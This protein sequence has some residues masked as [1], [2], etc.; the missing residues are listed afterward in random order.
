MSKESIRPAPDASKAPT[1]MF[2]RRNEFFPAQGPVIQRKC[3]ECA[4]E[5]DKAEVQTKLAIGTPDDSYER[6][7]DRVADRIMSGG[8]AVPE[9]TGISRIQ[10]LPAPGSRSDSSAV[11]QSRIDARRGSGRPLPASAQ[12]FFEP[13]LGSGL[14][15]VR[16]HSDPEAQT[17]ARSVNARAFTYGSDI[18]FGAGQYKPDTAAGQHLM[19]HELTHTV[20]QDAARRVQRAP[21]APIEITDSR[22]TTVPTAD[23]RIAAASCDI[24]CDSVNIGV[25]HAMPLSMHTSRGPVLAGAAGSNG[26]GAALHFIRNSTAIPAGNACQTCTDWKMI[27]ILQTNMTTDARAKERY[28]DNASNSTPF[29]D[30]AYLTGTGRHSIPSGY[31]D[32]GR[33]VNTTRSIYDR[34]FRTN[35]NLATVANKDFFWRAETHVVGV[36]PGKD[37]IL[38]GIKYGF[39]RAWDAANSNHG[40]VVPEAPVCQ[41]SP[42]AE[43][44][45]T[46][47]TDT[48]VP[49]YQFE[50]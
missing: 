19:A 40:P 6:E 48:S 32:A 16:V 25:L 12:R 4:A 1:R 11:S 22:I 33:E 44:I 23:Q 15:N 49:G 50:T 45:N 35:A 5:D 7:A 41:G 34:P 27:Q 21:A 3:A 14:G 2:D 30:D 20:Q 26:I 9:T 29:Y 13:R 43:F 28:V 37:K 17:M 47:K 8:S 46:L 10:R 39:T 24:S 36:K 31:V 18:Y 42:T 38:G